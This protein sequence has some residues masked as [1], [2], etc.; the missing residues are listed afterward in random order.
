MGFP[1]RSSGAPHRR[2][3]ATHSPAGRVAQ[4]WQTGGHRDGTVHKSMVDGPDCPGSRARSG[5]RRARRRQGPPAFELDVLR[6]PPTASPSA[7]TR[8][9][10]PMTGSIS[11]S[12]PGTVRIRLP[13]RRERRQHLLVRLVRVDDQ[14]RGSGR[15]S[16]LRRGHRRDGNGGGLVRPDA[17]VKSITDLKGSRSSPPPMQ[18]STRSSQLVLK[19]A[20]R[21]YPRT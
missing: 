15:R 1:S 3:S 18:A 13:P 7:R 4:A 21:Q 17:G 14:S 6:V 9:I 5:R 11:T 2:P 16:R 19:T 10:T 20:G 12:G 8:A